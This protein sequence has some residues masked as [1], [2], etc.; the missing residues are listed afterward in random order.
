[1]KTRFL[2]NLT[3]VT[4]QNPVYRI[5]GVKVVE[6][7]SP[8][9]SVQKI[10]EGLGERV[11]I[12]GADT[13]FL[14]Y[15]LYPKL[16]KENPDPFLNTVLSVFRKYTESEGYLKARS[17]TRLNDFL[18]LVFARRFLHHLLEELSKK[19]EQKQQALGAGTPAFGEGQGGGAGQNDQGQDIT[20]VGQQQKTD[21][22]AGGGQEPSGGQGQADGQAAGGGIGLSASEIG[23]AVKAALEKAAKDA[24]AAKDLADAMGGGV[25]PGVG[26][27]PAP[28][29]KLLNLADRVLSV[30]WAREVLAMAREI[31]TP[32]FV[33]LVKEKERRGDEV[34]GFRRTL[35]LDRALPRELAL[36]D[37]LFYAKLASGG[38]LSREYY[39]TR[40]GAYYV[41]IDRS[42]SMS[43]EKTVWARSVAL[44]LFKLA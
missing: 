15:S 40:E 14:H 3:N 41:L 33:H 27:T 29:E 20:A 34:A 30:S 22:Q 6:G 11:F 17:I 31:Q 35:R 39:V 1:M 13:F 18:S 5:W 7:L 32:R 10:W 8:S 43:G 2:N 4:P 16:R 26:K 37:D 25:G 44:A 9:P 38:L 36:D 23:E 28:L 19:Q 21:D 42:G 12:T 24:E